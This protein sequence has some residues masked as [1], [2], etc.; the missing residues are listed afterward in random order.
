MKL[1]LQT[2][3]YSVRGTSD[4]VY[5]VDLCEIGADRYVVNLRYGR[6]GSRLRESTKTPRPVSRT[7]AEQIHQ[8]LVDAKITEGYQISKSDTVAEEGASESAPVATSESQP[9]SAPSQARTSELGPRERS[10]L[11]RLRDGNASRSNWKLSRAIW[12]AGELQIREAE[13]LLHGLVSRDSMTNYCIA[14]AMGQLRSENSIP[15][16]R[17]LAQNTAAPHVAQIAV[18]AL[19]Q[20]VGE[21]ERDRL[22]RQSIDSLPPPLGSFL[23]NGS[24]DAFETT[25][26]NG[27]GSVCSPDLLNVL[28]FIDRPVCRR[29]LLSAI[30]ASPLRPPHFRPLRRLFKSAELRRDGQMFGALARKFEVTHHSFRVPSYTWRGYKSPTLGED[31]TQ[32]FSNRTRNYLRRRIWQTLRRLGEAQHPDF[33]PMAVGCLLAITDDDSQPRRTL[34]VYNWQ[35]HRSQRIKLDDFASYWAFNQLL[36]QNSPRFQAFGNQPLFRVT[37]DSD[38][39]SVH[40]NTREEAFPELWRHQPRGLLHLLTESRCRHVHE[41]AARAIRDCP[42]FCQQIPIDAL[43]TLLSTGYEITMALGLE[44]AVALYDPSNPDPNLVAALANCSHSPARDQARTWIESKREH[45]FS[46]LDFALAILTSR[47][48]DTRALGDQSL[49]A[50]PTDQSSKQ[51]LVGKLVGFMQSANQDQA[52]VVSD[53]GRLLQR[54]HFQPLISQLGEAVLCD[55]LSHELKEVQR[56]AGSVV[57]GHATLAKTPTESIL[58]CMLEATETSVR[59]MGIK[60]I[61]DLPEPTLAENALMLA[62]LACHPLEDIRKEIRPVIVRVAARHSQFAK[63]IA[64]ELIRR[65]LTSGAPDGVPTHT[66]KILR[67]DLSDHLGHVSSDTVWKLLRSR[68]GP[69]QELGGI[70]LTTHISVESLDVAEWVKLGRHPVVR[71]RSAAW[72][73]FENHP[74][75]IQQDLDTAVGILDSPWEDSRQFGFQY[76]RDRCD[77]FKLTATA[78]INLCDSARDDVQRFGRDM[79]TR[80]FKAEDGP[81]YVLKLSEHPSADLQLFVTN[82]LV[83][84]VSGNAE[85]FH[86]ITPYLISILSRV[87]KSRVAKDRVLE[88]LRDEISKTPGAAEAISQILSRISATC[89]IGDRASTIEAMLELHVACPEIE[90]PLEVR[91]TEVR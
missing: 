37:E 40:P 52:S 29:T 7:E 89:A 17:K 12:R 14:W 31:A 21:A 10:I 74:H 11:E 67:E 24:D 34:E 39:D 18:E 68:S 26:L 8:R 81:E 87:N 33:V 55:L 54:S 28:Y 27:L 53:V 70:L 48:A 88:F 13:P 30:E 80:Y 75:R 76:F 66:S 86:Q 60:I 19:R 51:V 59:A 84:H 56:F 71:V 35:Q 36:F 57:L 38:F 91:E 62:G 9:A 25:F 61:A 65:L 83:E 23:E 42:E 46:D 44:L 78:L 15:V 82:F 73:S 5:E 2:T 45:F 90:L 1:I 79:I 3:L 77:Q 63:E 32:S 50:F 43:M 47:F 6:R 72:K 4:Q 69:A 41:F 16:L 64:S 58:R 22:I 20:C 49:Y 85:R